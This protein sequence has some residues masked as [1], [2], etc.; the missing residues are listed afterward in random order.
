MRRTGIILL[1]TAFFVISA[2]CSI[3][4]QIT[5]QVEK[6][7]RDLEKEK[8]LREKM[9]KEVKE[10]EI[11]QPQVQETQL[12]PSQEKTLVKQITVTGVTLVKRKDIDAITSPY[13]N[14][15][16]YLRDMQKVADLI[17]DLY[18]KKGYITSRAYLPPQKI[19]SGVLEV[20]VLEGITG[21]IN[22]KGNRYFRTSLLRNKI[23]LKKGEPFEYEA[24][25]KGLSRINA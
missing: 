25:K 18:R 2:Q 15:E 22:I 11:E 23:H 5:G 16:L 4:A 6:T 20:R 14:K 21:D 1:I 7:T 3:F 24:L 17:T 8:T 12:P 9:E 19:E 13:L 10:P